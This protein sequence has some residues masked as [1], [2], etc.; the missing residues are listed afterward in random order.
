MYIISGE[1]RFTPRDGETI[2]I[3]AGDCLFFP[4]QT[5]GVWHIRQ[6]TRKVYLM[7]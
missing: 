3:A 7:I 1:C 2:E 6:S 5:H 4:E